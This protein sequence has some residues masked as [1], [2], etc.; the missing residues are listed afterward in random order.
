MESTNQG[1][2]FREPVRNGFA[3]QFDLYRHIDFRTTV[4]S[5]TKCAKS[6]MWV[7]TVAYGACH[8]WPHRST[9]LLGKHVAPE[10]VAE[11]RADTCLV[12]AEEVVAEEQEWGALN[13]EEFTT[14]YGYMV[15]GGYVL[16]EF[17]S[18]V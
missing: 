14:M 1:Y 4:R 11:A 15:H 8:V 6:G 12:L 18:P 2:D 9:F 3:N 13:N 5:V 7:V 17:A 10:I 16:K